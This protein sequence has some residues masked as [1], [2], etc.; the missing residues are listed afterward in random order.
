MIGLG[1]NWIGDSGFSGG[2]GFQ[3]IGVGKPEIYVS[4]NEGQAT[5]TQIA[6]EKKNY[7]SLY[8][9]YQSALNIYTNIG[10]N[11]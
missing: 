9:S 1:W 2:L 8:S 7:N 6:E 4:D 11:F 3:S 5:E 10:W